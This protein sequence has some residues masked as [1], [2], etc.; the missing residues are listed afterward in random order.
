MP[1]EQKEK[2]FYPNFTTKSGGMGLGLALVKN[3]IQ[4]AGGEITFESEAGEGTTF[5]MSLPVYE[6]D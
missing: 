5:V 6:G 4:S 2:V 3:I 1:E